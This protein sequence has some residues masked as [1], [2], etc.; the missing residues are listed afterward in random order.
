MQSSPRRFLVTLPR[1]SSGGITRDATPPFPLRSLD[2]FIGGKWVPA[3]SGRTSAVINPADGIVVARVADMGADETRAAIA[4]AVSA[5]AEWSARGA[6]AR[7]RVL[8]DWASSMRANARGLGVL[9][10]AEAGKP[11]AE[12]VGEVN[13]AADFFDWFSEE[14]KRPIG[15][16]LSAPAPNRR[17]YTTRA[18]VGVAAALTPWNFPAAMPARKIAAALAAGCTMVLRPSFD[19]PLSALALAQLGEDAG[20]PA[21]VLNVV[22]G[23]D[24]DATAGVLLASHDVRKVSFT[25]STRV[26]RLLAAAA[27]PT[28]KRVSLELGGSAPFIVFGDADIDAAVEGALAAKF[29][30]AGQTCVC[31]NAFLVDASVAGAFTDA[32]AARVKAL[33]VGDGLTP[34]ITIGPLISARAAAGAEAFVADA[35]ARGARV[36]A[37][38][39]R[40]GKSVNG[41][42]GHFFQPTV[43]AGVPADANCVRNEIFGPIAPIVTFRDEADALRIAGATR[44]GLAA[45]VFTR[46]GARATR[47]A[48]ALRVGMVG[49]NVGLISTA[50]APFGGVGDSGYGREGAREGLLEYTETKYVM[51]AA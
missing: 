39:V 21:G 33:T 9:L 3:S 50:N 40:G 32:L 28:L 1:V 5:Q 27:T 48:E 4:A 13:Y 49:V 14:A 42:V 26:G 10:C 17:Q 44:A 23:T 45:Y 22:L 8:R 41:G 25:G 19:T 36:V 37:G 11:L 34:G 43:L 38:G 7:A 12:A 51:T 30:N 24:H 6:W 18:P 2:G 15:D 31:A 46:D 16:V 29:R 20:L 35:V 47:I